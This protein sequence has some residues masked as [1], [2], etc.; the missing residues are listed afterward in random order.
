MKTK[1]LLINAINP[2]REIE[3]SMP[4]LGLGYLVSALREEFGEETIEF[5]I[6]DRR[7]KESLKRFK[8]DLV[9]ITSVSQNYNLAQEYA[10]LTKAPVLVGGIHLT[11][12]PSSLAKGNGDWRHWRG[13][14]DFD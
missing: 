9:G 11:S 6:V 8:P 2:A 4:P 5:K 13:R 10:R 1:F 3:A 7:V 14:K 12:L